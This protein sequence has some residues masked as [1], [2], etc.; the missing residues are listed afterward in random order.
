MIIVIILLISFFLNFYGI[1]WGLPS[2]E[3]TRLILPSPRENKRIFILLQ[4]GIKREEEPAKVCQL[5]NHQRRCLKVLDFYPA[6]FPSDRKMKCILRDYLLTTSYD[7]EYPLI[8]LI[9]NLKEEDLSL[10]PGVSL[11]GGPFIY[12]L[13]LSLKIAQLFNWIQLDSGLTFYLK[14]PE[15]LKRVYLTGRM[16]VVVSVLISTLLL[17]SLGRKL[18][19]KDTGVF[20][21][22]AFS[23]SPGIVAS[24]HVIKPYLLGIVFILLYIKFTL[25]L[26]DDG[27][28]S[29]YI[30]AG[31]FLGL[32]CCSLLVFII[33]VFHLITCHFLR[34]EGRMRDY[35]NSLK[36]PKLL[37]SCLFIIITFLLANLFFFYPFS[38]SFA[39]LQILISEVSFSLSLEEVS[40]NIF[41]FFWKIHGIALSFLIAGGFFFMLSF[42]KDLWF[43]PLLPLLYLL[44]FSIISPGKERSS[45]DL[46]IILTPFS[47]LL[48]GIGVQKLLL[49]KKRWLKF[50]FFILLGFTFI[51]CLL[52]SWNFKLTASEKGT[53]FQAGL[54]INQKIPLG[55]G[56]GLLHTFSPAS[57][58]PFDFRRFRIRVYLWKVP[59]TG[60]VYLPE[61]FIAE[62]RIDDLLVPH[63]QLVKSFH[64][65]W[66][67]SAVRFKDY[68]TNANHPVYIYQKLNY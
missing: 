48:A 12:T 56:I 68:F 3:R 59:S 57:T 16:V 20:S 14:N 15:I 9:S 47:S 4:E 13:R 43:L 29:S 46:L 64:P 38:E 42:R 10:N 49:F 55:S 40:K 19:G 35:L 50:L 52:Y 6:R 33:F 45:L 44:L 37:L 18:Y 66:P 22:L 58:P 39:K 63:Y 34:T 31:V 65:S 26:K 62:R 53:S 51:H 21:A 23:F 7:N 32:A 60:K 67:L 11:E 1:E 30:L 8:T 61:Y 17:Y 2:A 54:W 41:S 24:A 5:K 36:D 27:K 28:D 25:K